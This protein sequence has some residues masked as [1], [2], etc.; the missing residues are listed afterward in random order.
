M[1]NINDIIYYKPEKGSK[2]IKCK[3]IGVTYDLTNFSYI[4]ESKDEK[5]YENVSITRMSNR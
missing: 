3:V 2:K 1:F 5:I 4:L